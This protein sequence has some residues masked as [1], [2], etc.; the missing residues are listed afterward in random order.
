[1]AARLLSQ[2]LRERSQQEQP[3][4]TPQCCPGPGGE[5]CEMPPLLHCPQLAEPVPPQL[6]R[7]R[8]GMAEI[9][10]P[11]ICSWRQAGG[12][13]PPLLPLLGRSYCQ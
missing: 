3:S 13:E 12:P 6:L 1:M 5:P 4:S 11:Q 8:L 7:W 9:N 2:S 10:R